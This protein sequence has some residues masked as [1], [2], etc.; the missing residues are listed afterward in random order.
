MQIIKDFVY[1][2]PVFIKGLVSLVLNLIHTIK[3]FIIIGEIIRA[4]F[5]ICF[6]PLSQP[7]C[8]L[9]FYLYWAF[10]IFYS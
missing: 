5:R 10:E 3:A 9:H 1:F 8:K 2:H 6:F 4:H 7:E